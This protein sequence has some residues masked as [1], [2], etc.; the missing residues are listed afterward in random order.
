MQNTNIPS[1]MI[2][3][4]V[5]QWVSVMLRHGSSFY[6]IDVRTFRSYFFDLLAEDV[7]STMKRAQNR[8]ISL[9]EIAGLFDNPATLFKLGYVLAIGSKFSTLQR[10]QRRELMRKILGL[11]CMLKADR[12]PLCPKGRFIVLT[13]IEV[14][15]LMEQGKWVRAHRRL[16]PTYGLLNASLRNLLDTLFFDEHTVGGYTHGPY[17][18]SYQF[19]DNHRSYVLLAREF[20]NLRP[21]ELWEE[22]SDFPFVAAKSYGI[23]REVEFD[24][25]M[26]GNVV[27]REQLS[28]HLISFM[29]K[30]SNGYDWHVVEDEVKIINLLEVLE[31]FTLSLCKTIRKMSVF[32]LGKKL[33]EIN[34]FALKPLKDA[35][36]VSWLPNP[37]VYQRMQS[38][39]MPQKAQEFFKM[40][41]M[42]REKAESIAFE[43]LNPDF[44]Y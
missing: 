42:S 19:P 36:K 32:G 44:T 17:N 26:F 14:E 27:H 10:Q 4:L 37:E 8:G 22:F 30:V 34:F 29:V 11:I 13:G 33:A 12:L 18:V 40:L 5:R 43:L 35:I 38:R 2:D 15:K 24:V 3:A 25:D 6:P 31:R 41:E 23:Y 28:D 39:K 21:V 9:Q 1:S 20:T 16:A 7:Y